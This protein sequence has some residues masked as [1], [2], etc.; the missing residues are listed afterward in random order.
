MNVIEKL[1][2]LLQLNNFELENATLTL[3]FNLTFDVSLRDKMVKVGFLQKLASLLSKF[4][5]FLNFLLS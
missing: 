2:K 4:I 3:L 5:T 1:P